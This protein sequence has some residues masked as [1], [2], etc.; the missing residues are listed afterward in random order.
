MRSRLPARSKAYW[1][2]AGVA[3]ASAWSKLRLPTG[4]VSRISLSWRLFWSPQSP[5][6]LV[7]GATSATLRRVARASW[8]WVS[9]GKVSAWL[10][11]ATMSAMSASRLVMLPWT[12]SRLISLS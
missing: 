4:S 12:P 11:R 6:V 5:L 3:V 10:A 8:A 2:S 7:D 1:S 9:R